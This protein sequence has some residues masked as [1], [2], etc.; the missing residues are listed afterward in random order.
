ML[1]HTL[2]F[3]AK[4]SPTPRRAGLS[5][6]PS[7]EAAGSVSLGIRVGLPG[8][9]WEPRGSQDE[10]SS[11]QGGSHRQLWVGLL[12]PSGAACDPS[13]HPKGHQGLIPILCLSTWVSG[14]AAF[15]PIHS[16]SPFPV[17]YSS[18]CFHT[19]T[20]LTRSPLRPPLQTPAQATGR[21]EPH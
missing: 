8:M 14:K 10:P 2:T 7:G 9:T 12:Q 5:Y 16:Y 20:I 15:R 17:K 4:C 3:I 21:I 18:W 19:H 11:C 6:L 13:S 1:T